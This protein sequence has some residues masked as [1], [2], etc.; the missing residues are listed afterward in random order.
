MGEGKSASVLLDMLLVPVVLLGGCSST[1]EASHLTGADVSPLYAGAPHQYVLAK[2]GPPQHS[3]QHGEQTTDVYS[4]DPEGP[5]KSTKSVV[6]SLDVMADVLTLGLAEIVL[7]PLEYAS[8]HEPTTYVVTYGPD[9]RVQQVQNTNQS[10]GIA[11]LDSPQSSAAKEP[12]K[13]VTEPAL[14]TEE[15]L[16]RSS[17]G[18]SS[19]TKTS[20]APSRDGSMQPSEEPELKQSST[21]DP[22]PAAIDGAS[23]DGSRL[24][25]PLEEKLRN[26]RDGQSLLN[27]VTALRDINDQGKYDVAGDKDLMKLMADRTRQIEDP[28]WKLMC[29]L[30]VNNIREKTRSD[31]QARNSRSP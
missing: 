28:D 25:Q 24:V 1:I 26:T 19:A 6:E 29:E 30:V 20:N 3:Y 27:V 22:S 4:L 2:L 13:L 23:G 15:P 9:D 31:G 10:V 7:T 18:E 17:V 8:K 11:A 16:S 21:H 14:P 12:R 5:A